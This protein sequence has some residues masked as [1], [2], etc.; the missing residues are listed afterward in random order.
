MLVRQLR[1]FLLPIVV[2]GVIPAGLAAWEHAPARWPPPPAVSIVSLMLLAA[3]LYLLASTNRLFATEGAG[4][5]VPW[6]PPSRLVLRGVY[7]HVRNPMITGVFLVILA[8]AL[9]LASAAVTLWFAFAVLVNLVYIPLSEEPGLV[10]RF[11]ED[12]RE[13]QR[14]V[15][16]WIPRLTPW[17]GAAGRR[18]PK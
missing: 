10:R 16:R 15:P 4:T 17:G 14:N 11:G 12:Y 5:L 13:Y 1:A 7:R 3:G 18:P 6:D 9:A 8:E 2:A